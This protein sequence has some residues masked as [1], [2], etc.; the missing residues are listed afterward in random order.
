MS[1]NIG[2]RI[3]V[4]AAL[5]VIVTFIAFIVYFDFNQRREILKDLQSGVEETGALA[6][7][8]ISGWLEGRQLLVENIGQNIANTT[9]AGQVRPLVDRK[10]LAD[11][12]MFSY[13][14]SSEGDMIMHPDEALPEGYDPRKRP[15]YTDAVAAGASTL[16]EP[17]ADASTG[18][19]IVTMATPVKD[20]STVRGVVGGDI[21]IDVLADIVRTIDLGGVGYAFLVNDQGTILVHP[22]KDLTLKPMTEAFPENTPTVRYGLDGFDDQE[23]DL[24]FAFFPV[25][26][27]PSVK[28][29]LGFAIDREKAF[30]A[31]ENFRFTAIITAVI[32]VLAINLALGI[33]VRNW[34]STPVRGMTGA[35]TRLADGDLGVDIPGTNKT[36]EIGAMA[37]AVLVFKK[38]AEEVERLAQENKAANAR[39]EE[40]RRAALN[41]MADSFEKT[42]LTIVETV[43]Q[44]ANNTQQ[45]ASQLSDSANESSNRAIAVSNAA[46]ETT[47]SVQTVAA[48]TEQLS[49]AIREIGVQ[50]T[51]S[52]N[53]ASEAVQSVQKSGG[54]VGKLADAAQRIGEVVGLIQDI[55]GQTNLLALN[56]TIEAARAGEAGKGFAVV[57]NEVKSLATQTDKATGDIQSQVEG[58]QTSSN[59][60]VD[61]IK[62]TSGTIEK[63]NEY[64]NAIAA[65]VEE[66]GAATREIAD[67][68]QKAATGT[69]EVSSNVSAVTD[70]SSMVSAEAERLL[71]SSSEMQALAEKLKGEVQ[72]FLASVRQ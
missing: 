17:Y 66:Q 6:T 61:E 10:V 4:A 39:A 35:M 12:F 40:E 3:L 46:A 63:I 60:S 1:L 45:V 11:N 68:V 54:T 38:N 30:H 50:V 44:A 21:T 41:Q 37:A 71:E 58:I 20:G 8:N 55:A 48:A 24:M 18:G 49:A 2:S 23:G 26:G 36:D 34:V 22:D 65:A 64:A 69:Q 31:L 16:T 19:L 70:A 13:F 32:A 5:I 72:T 43:A 62:A 33:L 52:I 7:T 51:Q 29:S 28:W 56:A 59:Q 25:E 14:G 67:S 9:D 42:V 27:L 47:Q 15:W 57:A 53:I